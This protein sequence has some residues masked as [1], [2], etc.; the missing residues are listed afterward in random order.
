MP[1]ASHRLRSFAFVVLPVL[2]GHLFLPIFLALQIRD[3]ASRGWGAWISAFFL[4]ASCSGFF[5]VAG[6]WSW[7]GRIVR[8]VIT[9]LPVL[10]AVVS[11]PSYVEMRASELMELE[12]ALRLLLGAV[13]FVM[14]ILAVRGRREPDKALELA[15]PLRGGTF[16]VGQGGSTRMVNHH[17]VSDSQRYALDILKLNAAGVRARGLYPAVLDR[18]AIFGAEVVSPCDGM[19]AAAVDGLP[20]HAPPERDG[21]NRAGNHVALESGGATIYLAHLRRGSVAVQAGDHVRAGQL[22]GCVGNSGNATEPHLHIH[23]EEGPYPGRFSGKPGVPIL[24]DGRFL[25]RNDRVE[26]WEAPA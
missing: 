19:V 21:A 6:A 1:A 13:F 12:P 25:A 8:R 20:D 17:A 5:A 23:A 15:F 22:L 14:L 3:A 18:Y 7:F 11:F 26:A 2:V 10:A 9:M 24:L 4:S 16:I